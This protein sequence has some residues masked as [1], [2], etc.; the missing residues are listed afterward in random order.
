MANAE[1]KVEKQEVVTYVDVETVTL[2]LTVE[3]ANLV[4]DMLH[5]AGGSPERSRRGIADS[6]K[7]ALHL[8]GICGAPSDQYSYPNDI[9]GGCAIYFKD[10]E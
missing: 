10:Q 4:H 3:E 6:V 7:H 9:E 1:K 8:A 2:K 5:M